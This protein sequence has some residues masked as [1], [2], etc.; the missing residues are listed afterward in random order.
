[1]SLQNITSECNSFFVVNH[2]AISSDCSHCPII[3][4]S[5]PVNVIK[6]SKNFF[7]RFIGVGEEVVTQSTQNLDNDR[8]SYYVILTEIYFAN[9][10]IT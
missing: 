9:L 3:T 6:F 10:S 1:M 4:I 2:S 7:K 5:A 8:L